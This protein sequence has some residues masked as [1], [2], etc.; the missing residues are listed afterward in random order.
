MREKVLLAGLGLGA[1]AGGGFAAVLVHFSR[2]WIV[3]PRVRLDAP[4]CPAAEEVHLTAPDGIPLYGWYLRAGDS[5]PAL[6]LCHGYQRAIEETF[7]LGCDLH[8]RGFNVLMFD[9]RGCGRSGG[10]YTTIGFHEPLDVEGAI[11]WLRRRTAGRSPI[12]VLGIS[13]G[14]AAALAAV[15]RRP[16]VRALVT[17]SAFATLRG[18]IAQRLASL[19]FPSLQL[20]HLSMRTAERMCRGRADLV[21]PVEA[22]RRLDHCPVLLIHGTADGIV[23]YQHALELDRAIPAPHEV[24]ALEGVPH[25]MARFYARDEYVERVSAFFARHLRAAGPVAA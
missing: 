25:A 11:D 13:M 4:A 3:P 2:R 10:R 20:H 8:E 1:L 19:R 18:A 5:D 6:V 7:A 15:A 17:D 12:G 9:F 14:G 16:E 24:W 23:P 21:R 22:A